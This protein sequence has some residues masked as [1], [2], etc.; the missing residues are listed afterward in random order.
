MYICNSSLEAQSLT[1]A[2]RVLA[3]LLCP[4]LC[5]LMPSRSGM[6]DVGTRYRRMRIIQTENSSSL[7]S[8]CDFDRLIPRIAPDVSRSTIALDP[9]TASI[10]HGLTRETSPGLFPDVFISQPLRSHVSAVAGC[11]RRTLRVATRRGD[12]LLLPGFAMC[13]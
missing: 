1:T 3:P 10:V 2:I 5:W 8:S 11:P 13:A 9:R 7:P 6:A 4:G 12:L